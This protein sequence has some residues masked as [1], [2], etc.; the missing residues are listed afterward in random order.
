MA[1]ASD[2]PTDVKYYLKLEQQ[3]GY[4]E[5]RKHQGQFL[6]NWNGIGI[7]S[8]VFANYFIDCFPTF[9]WSIGVLE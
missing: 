1:L 8:R 2:G 4:V 5:E 7:V 6:N 9:P 3:I